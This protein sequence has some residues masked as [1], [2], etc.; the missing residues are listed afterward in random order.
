MRKA[1]WRLATKRRR[2]SR[3]FLEDKKRRSHPGCCFCKGGWCI[4]C[5]LR[6]C[7]HAPPPSPLLELARDESGVYLFVGRMG[8][9]I[10]S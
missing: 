7:L 9:K 4:A 2:A 3:A 5:C 6:P 10:E 8:E 1:K